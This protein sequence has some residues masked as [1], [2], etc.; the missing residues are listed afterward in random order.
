MLH[1]W[2]NNPF[3]NWLP[4]ADI[5]MEDWLEEN[6]NLPEL[7][8]PEH[9][10]YHISRTPYVR[11]MIKA[12]A[13]P[14]IEEIDLIW[15]RQTSKSTFIYNI[16][17]WAIDQSPGP[18]VML[19]PIKELAQYTSKDRIQEQFNI[20][21]PVCAQKTKNPNDYA[22]YEM[23]FK[24][25]VLSLIWAGSGSQVMS[26]PVQYALLDE[27]DEMKRTVGE[28]ESDP[29]LSIVEATSN[30]QNRKIIK[31][32][33]PSLPEKQIWQA[34]K[35]AQRTFE[36]WIACPYCGKRQI[37]IWP[38]IKWPKQERDTEKIIPVTYYE[39]IHCLKHFRNHEKIEALGQGQWRSRRNACDCILNDTITSISETISLDETLEDHSIVHIASH[40][41]K[42]YSPFAYGA[43][44]HGA[45]AF[46]DAQGDYIKK[47][48]WT[49]FWKAQP[50]V[51]TAQTAKYADILKNKIDIPPLICPADT[52]ALIATV[53][54][55]Q[56]GFWFMVVAWREDESPH[57]VHYGFL[58]SWDDVTRLAFEN[59][60]LIQGTETRI[61]V[62]RF[63]LDTGG[64]KYEADLTMTQA[65]YIWL[66]D[67]SRQDIYGVK[68]AAKESKS[69]RRVTLSIIDKMPGHGGEAIPGGI[70]VWIIDTSSFKDAIQYH[71]RLKEG[72]KGRLTFHNEVKKESDL[73]SHLFSEEKRQQKDGSYKWVQTKTH[74]HLLDCLDY[75]F[76]LADQECMGGTRI[77][78]P[79]DYAPAPEEEEPSRWLK[80]IDEM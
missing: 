54:P 72:K 26:R 48:D 35:S 34:M 18:A 64:S 4:P 76:A 6:V 25:M 23:K 2:L 49:K 78:A 74:N 45:K 43:F 19:F 36:Y 37:L 38:Q 61:H 28:G 68:G 50:Y 29:I 27:I 7:T 40:L 70:A 8:C 53:D 69:G 73:I 16:L 71:L 31:T 75:N 57:I 56:G 17:C 24:S 1:E 9:G 3:L 58:P 5:A 11:G 44:E 55:S 15:G 52:K 47:R 65:A 22:T 60:Y 21:R 20:C 77:L 41:P 51:K 14:Y 13:S 79:L 63:G 33:T 67:N 46:L 30:F 62:W 66:R 10:R 59:T 42:W 12:F 80:G 32:S 39:C